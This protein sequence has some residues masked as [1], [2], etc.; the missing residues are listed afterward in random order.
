[1]WRALFLVLTVACG[2]K[3]SNVTVEGAAR[4][5]KGGAVVVADD[6]RVLYVAGLE[7]WP[8]ELDGRRVAVTGRVE[9]RPGSPEPLVDD[10]GQ[11]SAGA[12]G[13]QTVIVDPTWRAISR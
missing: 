6:G 2:A 13:P 10:A 1:V 7:S 11:H 8:A 3:M 12:S 5:A 4:N 9:S